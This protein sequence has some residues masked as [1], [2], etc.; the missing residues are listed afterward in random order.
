VLADA[1]FG[2]HYGLK[3]DI[4]Y[5]HFEP[6]TDMRQ[7]NIVSAS[8]NILILSA[9][10]ALIWLKTAELFLTHVKSTPS[11]PKQN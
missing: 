9:L 5:A 6:S 11:K 2:P 10:T 4:G 8:A 3:S 7:T 1:R